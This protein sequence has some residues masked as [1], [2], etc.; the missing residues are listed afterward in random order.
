MTKKRLRYSELATPPAAPPPPPSP[1]PPPSRAPTPAAVPSVAAPVVLPPPVPAI[2]RPSVSLVADDP[3]P[4]AAQTFSLRERARARRGQVDLLVFRVG[5]EWFGVDLAAVEE[6]IDLPAVRHVPEMPPA[7]VGVVTVRAMLTPVFAPGSVLGVT[8]ELGA[9]ALVFR[10][11]RGRVA[12]AVDDVDDVHTLDLAQLR[13]AP[14]VD[15]R[16]GILLGVIRYRA[17]LLALVDAEALIAACQLVPL[18]ETA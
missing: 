8:G 17:A 5:T 1:A 13:D 14:G 18:L 4:A 6:A 3:A 15:A 16:D 11:A 12:I 7:M 2:G 9:S 10:R